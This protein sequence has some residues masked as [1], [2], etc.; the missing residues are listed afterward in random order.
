MAKY[1][2]D[3]KLNVINFYLEGNGFLSTAKHF[4]IDT[5]QVRDW[6][7]AYQLH[8]I[9]GIKPRKSKV[10]YSLELKIHILSHMTKHSLSTRETAALFNIPTFTTVRKWKNIMDTHGIE[11]LAPKKKGRPT[12]TKKKTELPKNDK[13]KSLKELL[14]ELEYLRAENACLKKLQ[15]LGNKTTVKQRVAIVNQLKMVY[16]ILVLLRALSLSK[17][18]FYYHQKNSH[19]S[20]DKLLK[21]KIKAIYHQHKGRYGY[22]RITAVLRNEVIINH[23][24]VQRLMQVQGLKSIV[25]PKK[26]RSYKGLLGR[27]ADNHLER[28]FNASRPNEKW[29]TDVTEFKVKGEKLYLSPILDLFNQEIISYQIARRPHYNM[30]EQ[31]LTQAFSKL[32]QGGELILHSDQG[33]QYQMSCYHNSLKKQGIIQSMS[34][35]GNCLDNAVIE[36]FFGILKTECF[37]TK[38]FRNL[39]ELEEELHE[40]IKYYN[41]ERIKIKLKGLSPVQYRT[42]SLP[43]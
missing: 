17:S 43:N 1:S 34:R 21:D 14:K 31:M 18:T 40:Y 22:R 13:D 33:W 37:Y 24:K 38:Q 29:V 4:S 5:S 16:P 19:D 26:Y 41:T 30:I 10:I 32:T 23:K 28:N 36:N 7:S 6:C 11:A 39:D 15:E 27:I 35:K 12:L 25:R 9:E 20:K 2:L 42:Q 8:G 3:F